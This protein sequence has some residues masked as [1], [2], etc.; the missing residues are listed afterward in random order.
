[1]NITTKPHYG[2]RALLEI[3]KA[4]ENEGILQ[5]EIAINQQLPNK[6]LD[7]IIREL[8][9]A[10]IICNYGRK[11]S[12]Y[13][14]STP[15]SEITIYMIFRAF[16][17]E[18]CLVDCVDCENSTCPRAKELC[19]TQPLWQ[20]LNKRMMNF[21]KLVTLQDLIDGKDFSTIRVYKE[22]EG[23]MVDAVLEEVLL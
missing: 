3:A 6:Y 14:L 18:L 12:G 1:M 9:A 8:K 22:V 15:A 17:P 11:K 23:K 2:I 20:E 16:E 10:K 13:R 7:H 5:K 21:M 4:E 19:P